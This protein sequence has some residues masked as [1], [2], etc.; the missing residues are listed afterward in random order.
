MRQNNAHAHVSQTAQAFFSAQQVMLL[1]WPSYSPDMSLI[2]HVW[3]FICLQ[4]VRTAGG[5]HNKNKHW[6][7]VEAIWDA[8]PQD[9]IQSLYDSM[10][11]R[12]QVLIAQ[13]GIH[14]KY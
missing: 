12:I 8:I 9:Y 1:P 13:R 7:Q 2:E 5:A 10:P 11:R 14:T 3:D 6:L 4:L